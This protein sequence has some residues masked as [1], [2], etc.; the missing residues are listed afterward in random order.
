M[1][2]LLMIRTFRGLMRLKIFTERYEYLRL[3]GVV[4]ESTFGYDRYLNQMLYTSKRWRRTRDKIIIRDNGC[5]LG[6]ENYEIHGKIF[7]HHMN[8]ITI[9][10]IELDRDIVYD[11][12]NLICSSLN[13]H[14]AI[15][16]GDSSLL[17]RLPVKRRKND[18]CPWR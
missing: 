9:E 7:V 6:M 18:T 13:T 5:D 16:Y 3:D 17:P 14:N 8:V 15:H 11:P 4:G 10:D 12:E 1:E 2:V